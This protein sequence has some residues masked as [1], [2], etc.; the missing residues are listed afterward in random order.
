MSRAQILEELLE[1]R[2]LFKL[3]SLLTDDETVRTMI[4]AP[5]VFAAV[6]PPFADTD[7]G[8]RL[9]ELRGWFD[10]F[11]EGAEISVS[12]N[13]GRKPPETMLARVHPVEAEFWSIRVTDPRETPGIRSLGAFSAKDEFIALRWD[14][15][16]NIEIFDDEVSAT[17]DAWRDLFH[18]EAP[19]DGSNLD[20]YISYYR[21]V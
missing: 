21:V 6:R 20:A 11:M 10:A 19:H 12:E 1:Q 13:P 17:I 3:E 2:G 14:Y 7:E 16:E 5:A 4:V 18:S 9:G 15:R 8:M